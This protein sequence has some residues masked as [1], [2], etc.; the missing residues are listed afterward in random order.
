MSTENIDKIRKKA[1]AIDKKLLA[2]EDEFLLQD[3]ATDPAKENQVADMYV[4][5]A[6]A[7]LE[8]LQQMN[9]RNANL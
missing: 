8:L 3:A 6:K 2:N 1:M 4:N 7:K 9:N 5:A